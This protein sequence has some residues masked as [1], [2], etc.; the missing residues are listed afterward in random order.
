MK[1]LGANFKYI[2][3]GCVNAIAEADPICHGNKVWLRNYGTNIK[4]VVERLE[5]TI[6]EANIACHGEHFWVNIC[7]G[8]QGIG[9]TNHSLL[10]GRQT[11]ARRRERQMGVRSFAWVEDIHSRLLQRECALREFV[12]REDSRKA[13]QVAAWRHYYEVD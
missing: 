2:V 1:A 7:F 3:A 10:G 4:L 6:V 9:S 8:M 12:T 11:L 5:I 13:R